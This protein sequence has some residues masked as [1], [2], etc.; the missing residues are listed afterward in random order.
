MG[1]YPRTKTEE[2]ALLVFPLAAI[3]L[4]SKQLPF[5]EVFF[6]L[7]KISELSVITT[8]SSYSSSMNVNGQWTVLF[9]SCLAWLRYSCLC[10]CFFNSWSL[11]CFF[12]FLREFH[13]LI[14]C[15]WSCSWFFFSFRFFMNKWLNLWFYEAYQILM[16]VFFVLLWSGLSYKFLR[17]L[18]LFLYTN[19]YLDLK[20]LLIR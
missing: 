6:S 13:A 20:A 12:F 4:A 17:E 9:C 7:K 19:H 11:I 10:F 15:V 18:L 8:S 5:D 14:C 1:W 3:R 2:A 16:Y